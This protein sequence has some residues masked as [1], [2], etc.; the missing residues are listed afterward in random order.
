M[1]MKPNHQDHRK[2]HPDDPNYPN[3]HNPRLIRVPFRHPLLHRRL[4]RRESFKEMQLLIILSKIQQERTGITGYQLQELYQVPRGSLVRLLQW[5]EKHAYVK[6]REEIVNG[7]ANKFYTITDKGIK[8]LEEIKVNWAKRIAV[9]DD[10]APFERYGFGIPPPHMPFRKPRNPRDPPY[11]SQPNH[12]PHK[13]PS[14]KHDHEPHL[15][16]EMNPDLRDIVDPEHVP[17]QRDDIIEILLNQAEMFQTKD[18]VIDF[19]RGHR[20]QLT[21]LEHRLNSRLHNI[22]STKSEIETIIAEIEKLSTFNLEELEKLMK[23]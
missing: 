6:V 1:S 12:F 7:R 18:D 14:Q 9:I 3:K 11:I 4:I 21:R 8:H 22:Q 2:Y 13:K 5:L 23:K 10:L 17:I 19:L 20:S 16:P 15:P